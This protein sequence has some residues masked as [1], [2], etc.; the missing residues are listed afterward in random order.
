[1]ALAK[2]FDFKIGGW[3]RP[4]TFTAEPAM[5]AR[6]EFTQSGGSEAWWNYFTGAQFY[7]FFHPG[8]DLYA[9]L[10]TPIYAM[11][12]GRV[13]KAGWS[14]YSSGYAVN[15]EIRPGTTYGHGHMTSSIRVSVGQIVKKGQLLGSVGQTG[16]ATGPHAHSFIQIGNRLYNL[17]QFMAGGV[18]QNNPAIQPYYLTQKHAKVAGPGIN[19]RKTPDLDVG[20]TNLFC[21]SRAQGVDGWTLPTG[22]YRGSTKIAAIDYGFIYNGDVGTDDGTFAKVSGP[23]A[24]YGTYVYISR[25]LTVIY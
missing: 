25:P 2:P 23:L 17:L 1:M 12:S 13:T 6:G 8:V 14:S 7:P 24:G 20:Y 3:F 19:I 11:E 5:W 15:V 10:G 21:T 9:T 4:S 18:Q 22:L 16:V